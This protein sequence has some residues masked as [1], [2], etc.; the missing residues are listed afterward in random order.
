MF[1]GMIASTADFRPERD[2]LIPDPGGAQC[3][4]GEK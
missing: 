4:L 1:G 2:R 3:P